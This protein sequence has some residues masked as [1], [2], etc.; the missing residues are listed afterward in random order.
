MTQMHSVKYY[1]SI[2]NP[3]RQTTI[4]KK[5]VV[6]MYIVAAEVLILVSKMTVRTR[7]QTFN[8]VLGSIKY[9]EVENLT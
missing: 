1:V 5:L 4:R 2:S 6:K 3:I 7:Y 9:R 8:R